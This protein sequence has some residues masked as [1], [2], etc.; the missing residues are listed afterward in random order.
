MY[1]QHQQ[2]PRLPFIELFALQKA[3]S[4]VLM[5]RAYLLPR[6]PPHLTNQQ[7]HQPHTQPHT[8]SPIN[9]PHTQPA[10]P[11]AHLWSAPRL[12]HMTFEGT[13]VK[14]SS[15]NRGS[16]W[17]RPSAMMATCR[18]GGVGGSGG[19]VIGRAGEYSRQ[20]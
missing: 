9:Q 12:M 5:V 8:H 18:G 6:I 13:T 10:S 19:Q 14:P 15:A 17:E 1:Q 11:T 2:L 3:A 4:V 7:Q 20:A 16:S